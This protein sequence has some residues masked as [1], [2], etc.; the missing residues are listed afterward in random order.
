MAK[1]TNKKDRPHYVDNIKFSA[2]VNEYVEAVNIAK[3]NE[4]PVPMVPRYIA[5]C[6]MLTSEG[7]SHA[8]N[9]VRYPFREE[10]VLDGIENCL[11]AINNY[12]ISKATRT[13]K[14]NAFS[15]FTQICF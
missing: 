15:Y 11:R 2:S 6:F 5:E 4:A 8:H 13:G 12:D 9:F 3:D 14:P 1:K 7:L 10:M